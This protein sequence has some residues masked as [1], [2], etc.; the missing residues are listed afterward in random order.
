MLAGNAVE[1]QDEA[2][3]CPWQSVRS[4]LCRRV[5]N[6]G[7]ESWAGLPALQTFGSWFPRTITITPAVR[8]PASWTAP[9]GHSTLG[10]SQAPM[11]VL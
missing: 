6:P 1:G 3:C 2:G 8:S 10:Q 7:R 4:A 5:G 11:T 9:A